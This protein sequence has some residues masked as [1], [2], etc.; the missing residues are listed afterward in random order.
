MAGR[1]YS[2]VTECAKLELAYIPST[3]PT[4]NVTLGPIGESDPEPTSYSKPTNKSTIELELSIKLES[5]IDI[6]HYSGRGADEGCQ[7]ADC[8]SCWSNNWR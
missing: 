1:K 5:M 8:H 2:S 7:R 4:D 3:K 6:F